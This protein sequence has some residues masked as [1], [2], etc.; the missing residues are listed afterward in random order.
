MSVIDRNRLH[1]VLENELE[2]FKKQ[3]TRSYEL[4]LKAQKSLL[5]GVPMNWM[6]RWAG[7]YP[8]FVKEAR[9]AHFTD[10]DGH[11]YIDF[12]LGDTGNRRCRGCYRGCGCT[13][14][15]DA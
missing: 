2:I 10:V 3:H 8:I 5:G 1:Q 14:K 7:G 9:G 13:Y 4:Y 11:E 6:V 15:K 12:C